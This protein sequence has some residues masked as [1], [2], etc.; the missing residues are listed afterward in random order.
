MTFPVG[1]DFSG[2]QAVSS[3]FLGADLVEAE[4][5]GANLESV[6]FSGAELPDAVFA[7]ASLYKKLM[8]LAMNR[9]RRRRDARPLSRVASPREKMKLYELGFEA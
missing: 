8:G 4:F 9:V 5:T 1:D 6:S 2:L 7:D 3:H